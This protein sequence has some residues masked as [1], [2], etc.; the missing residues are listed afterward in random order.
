MS[1][2]ATFSGT[3]YQSRLIAYVYVHIL[4]QRRLGWLGTSD[5]TPLAISGETDGPGD[6]AEIEFGERHPPIEVQ[7]KHGLT[8]GAKLQEVIERLRSKSSAESRM[9][10]VLAVNRNSSRKVHSEFRF[11]L[12]RLRSGR[13]DGLKPDT[14]RVMRILEESGGDASMLLRRLFVVK[15][16]FDHA[17]DPEAKLAIH[18]IESVL[19]DR[20]QA[21]NAW[22]KLETDAADIC[23]RRLRRTRKDLVDLLAAAHIKT[24]PLAKDEHWHR[25]LDVSKQLL[26]KRHAAAALTVLS[27]VETH[28][29]NMQVDPQVWYRLAQQRATALMQLARYDEAISSARR[30]L[31]IEPQGSHALVTLALSALLAGD[32]PTAITY[33]DRAL[34]AAPD[35][36]NAWGAQTQIAIATGMPRPEPPASVAASKHYRTIL[37]QIADQNNEWEHALEMTARLLAENVRSPEVLY[38]RANALLCLCNGD[39]SSEDRERCQEA[40]RLASELIDIIADDTHPYTHKSIVLRANARRALGRMTEA[41]ADLD[42]AG[43]LAAA[44][45]DVIGHSARWKLENGEKDAALEILRNP[46]VEG[47]PILLSLR[48]QLLAD[49]N[50]QAAARRDLDAA[51]RQIADARQPDVAR[52]TAADAALVL[53]DADLTERILE[54]VTGHGA[55]APPYLLIRGR[56]AFLRRDIDEGA[57]RYQE[58][59]SRDVAHRANYLAELGSRFLRLNRLSDAIRAFDAAGEDAL[60]A[61]SLREFATALFRVSDL[62]RA[63]RLIDRLAQ[64]GPLPEWA[65]EM[66]I[67]IALRREDVDAAINRLMELIE[68]RPPTA[69]VQLLLANCLIERGCA[70]D[71]HPHLDALMGDTRL[72]PSQRMRLA[73]LLHKA[74]RG[75]RALRNAFR[76]FREAPHDPYLHRSFINLAL[77]SNTEIPSVPQV[78]PETYVR[79]RNQGGSTREYTIYADAPIDPLRGELSV[80]DAEVMGLLGK[81]EGEVIL[82]KE[83]TWRE[84]RWTLEAVQPA[85]LRAVQDAMRHYEDRFPGEPFFMAGFSVGERTS[86]KR[87]APIIAI[88][89]QKKTFTGEIFSYYREHVIPLG[90]VAACLGGTVPN[91][92]AQASADPNDSGP[93]FVEYPD[94]QGQAD[95]RCAAFETTEVVLTRSALQTASELNLLDLLAAQYALI[96]PRSLLNELQNEI[97]E[98]NRLVT[99]GQTTFMS[100]GP[101]LKLQEFEP[102]HPH[103]VQQRNLSR[104][105]LKWLEESVRIEVRPLQ[106]IKPLPSREEEAREQ[107]GYS[108]YDAVALTQ[109]YHVP[110]YADDLGLRRLAQWTADGPSFSTVGLLCAMAERGIITAEERDG[111]LLTLIG[112]HYAFVR[113]S[114]ALLELALRRAPELG[115]ARLLTIFALLGGPCI[116]PNE[117]A[118]MTAQ[119]VKSIAIAPVQQ[120]LHVKDTVELALEAMSMNWPTPLCGQ[121]IIRA[122]TEELALM[123][124]HLRTV[125]QTCAEF[126][127]V[128]M[129]L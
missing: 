110:M 93:L 73:Q 16:D 100:A 125:R 123:P 51:L 24:R 71:A 43:E 80:A 102:S 2:S 7:A 28:I 129:T 89:E 1:G 12:D 26:H 126:V 107:I 20:T 85:I 108:S 112:R 6:D 59:A 122:A 57:A 66:A 50:E 98:A 114:R 87:F 121:L 119:I 13:D 105:L 77:M 94:P 81:E 55:A 111:H 64:E 35:D 45:H 38:C 58:A 113:P 52:F 23:A 117:A 101:G 32:L 82:E 76:A 68:R 56:L 79:L 78:G 74:G 48:A 70:D 49:R 4:A 97:R 115:R 5:D 3:T 84:Q 19:E 91:V 17:D 92:M 18:L 40:E 72:A 39:D 106:A 88:L 124:Q 54:G 53:K 99:E 10:V 69:E 25:Q 90:V 104:S 46:R 27:Q 21:Q 29:A 30:A 22:D 61:A 83:G 96:A 109:H 47:N 128:R 37:A 41:Q 75:D 86:V 33:A 44:D 9:C 14:E 63:R 116:G 62:V 15:A 31:D 103:L 95:S 34:T 42:L 11:D 67:D 120:L 118:R 65:I 36:P 60:P 127:R 8:A